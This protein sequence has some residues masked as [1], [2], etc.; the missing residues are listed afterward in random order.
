MT[1]LSSLRWVNKVEST[2]ERIDKG[3]Q[4][5]VLEPDTSQSGWGAYSQGIFSGGQWHPSVANKHNDLELHTA[6]L[7][8][9][10]L[11]CDLTSQ[12][13]QLLL[14]LIIW[15]AVILLIAINWQKIFGN[16]VYPEIFG[17]LHFIYLWVWMLRLIK[18]LKFFMIKLSGS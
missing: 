9:H 4:T 14:I 13:I 18:P 5:F 15:E 17:W 8:L 6:W 7:G 10:S 3:N 1:F 16:V 11:C 2:N 12:H